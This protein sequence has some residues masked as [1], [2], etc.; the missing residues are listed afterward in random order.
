MAGFTGLH[1]ESGVESRKNAAENGKET[2][3]GR[4]KAKLAK[5]L[6]V[7]SAVA[8]VNCSL[9]TRPLRGFIPFSG[10]DSGAQT[11]TGT[12][13]AGD[14]GMGNEAGAGGIGGTGGIAGSTGGAGGVSGSGGVAGIDTGGTGGTGGG[15]PGGTTT[16]TPTPISDA[17]RAKWTAYVNAYPDLA[18]AFA[19][20]SAAY[21]DFNKDMVVYNHLVIK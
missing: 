6:L 17:E 15:T 5:Y 16:N 1:A 19:E 13:V 7:A 3:G 12:G 4:L 8:L 2:V 21:K 20:N 14:S 11:D 10:K 18:K 9:D